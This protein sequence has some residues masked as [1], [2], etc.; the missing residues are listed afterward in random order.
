MGHSGQL[1]RIHAGLEDPEDLI[2]DMQQGFN[3]STAMTETTTPTKPDI[4]PVQVSLLTGFLGSGKTTL[5][6]KLVKH[7]DMLETAV[8]INEFGEIGLDHQLIE[9]IDENTVLLNAGC[10]CCTIQGDLVN[11]LSDLFIKRVKEEVPYFRRVLIETTGLA[12]P[13]PIIHTL[14]TAPVVANRFAL[15][16]YYDH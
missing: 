7:P 8:L 12:D 2:E 5:L 16:H 13:A 15:G 11:A 14:M 10:L 1:I 3:R 6:N 4:E 9:R